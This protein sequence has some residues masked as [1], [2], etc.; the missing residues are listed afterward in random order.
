MA[1]AILA[2]ASTCRLRASSSTTRSGSGVG[3]AS[4]FTPSALR[5]SR[6][7]S[8]ISKI[9][10]GGSAP[11]AIAASTWAK[12]ITPKPPSLMVVTHVLM[13]VE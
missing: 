1:A 10:T 9:A 8:I 3:A 7:I 11:T 5:L 4:A 12:L 13:R 6:W 2:T